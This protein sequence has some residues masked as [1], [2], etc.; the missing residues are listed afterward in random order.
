MQI[1]RRGLLK[2][3]ARQALIVP[4]IGLL[5]NMA[6]AE[7]EKQRLNG[8]Y[9]LC[10][11]HSD[12]GHVAVRIGGNGEIIQQFK[13]QDRAHGHAKNAAG[14]V[15]VF[16]RRPDN[17]LYHIRQNGLL[18]TLYAPTGRH[19]FGHGVFSHD[20]KLLYCAEND[21]DHEDPRQTGKIGIW[22]LT[23]GL[24]IGEFLSGGIGVHQ[25][26]L[27]PDGKTLAIANGGILTHPDLPRQKLNLS[28]MRPN[29]A[30]VNV[31]NGE[32]ISKLTLPKSLHQL[33][34]RHIDVALNGDICVAMQYQ[35]AK[36]DQVAL[37][38]MVDN[39][40]QLK[41]LSMPN[42]IL[43]QNR[44]Y[45]GSICYDISGQFFAATSPRG[46]LATF[47]SKAGDYIDQFNI[48]DVCAVA[49]SKYAG[50]FILASGEGAVVSYNIIKKTHKNLFIMQDSSP[51]YQWDNHMMAI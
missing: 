15:V 6:W 4:A 37:I 41:T 17:Q 24:K 49:P 19:F 13:L 30:L 46:N 20:G 21:F 27:L 32:L 8:Q 35:G 9:M 42:D 22:D 25:I 38:A 44:Q 3:A 14:D 29:L 47:F 18:T 5:P 40:R 12:G 48:Q 11:K 33:S 26:R 50:N 16:A 10:A 43:A 51:K 2:S 28:D 31:T 45:I 39:R 34:I 23:K 7:D 36:A 1:S